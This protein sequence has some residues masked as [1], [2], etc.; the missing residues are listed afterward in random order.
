MEK[1]S[2]IL[3]P[4]LNSRVLHFC[5]KIKK[6]F[7]YARNQ[8][9][10]TLATSFIFFASSNSSPLPTPPPPT[11]Q[12]QKKKKWLW[13]AVLTFRRGK[14]YTEWIWPGSSGRATYNRERTAWKCSP[15]FD[16]KRLNKLPKSRTFVQ[17][18]L[19]SNYLVPTI[20]MLGVADDAPP[21][22]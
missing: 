12:L 13:S 21:L 7:S 16:G 9:D 6:I 19:W 3:A 14:P 22:Q 1:L 20:S 17:I 15:R 5:K 11:S 18:C 2:A 4:V 8:T 10:Q